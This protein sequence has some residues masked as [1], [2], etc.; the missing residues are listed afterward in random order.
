M[1]CTK[2]ISRNVNQYGL[3]PYECY[4]IN[5]FSQVISD[6][7]LTAMFLPN[8]LSHTFEEFWEFIQENAEVLTA[9]LYVTIDWLAY[10]FRLPAMGPMFFDQREMGP[11][12]N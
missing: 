10:Y 4:V 5:D 8:Y 11:L 7:Y 12:V 9:I 2:T 6:L 3:N 1:E